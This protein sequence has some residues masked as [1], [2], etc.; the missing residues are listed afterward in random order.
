MAELAMKSQQKFVADHQRHPVLDVQPDDFYLE[1]PQV[2]GFSILINRLP[3]FLPD[4]LPDVQPDN[5][6]LETPLRSDLTTETLRPLAY[7]AIALLFTLLWRCL[8]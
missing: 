8:R 5:F 7:R 6:Y 4:V 3:D 1:T 2:D